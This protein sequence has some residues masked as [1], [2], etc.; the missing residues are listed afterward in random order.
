MPEPGRKRGRERVYNAEKTR[1]AILDA[2]EAV[3]AER[4]FH[5]TA[6][7]AIAAEAGY[8]KSLIFQYFGDK[9]GLYAQVL[10]RADRE[11]N[12][13]LTR[14]FA[15]LLE[16]ETAFQVSQLRTFL[17]TMVQ[18]LF[19]YLLKHPR[20]VRMLTWEMA[21]GWQT[22]AQIASQFSTEDRDQFE[23][24]FHKARSAGLFRSGFV[25]TL[26]LA[27]VG[28]MCLSYLTSLPLYQKLLPEEDVASAESLAQAREY[29]VDFVVAGMLVDSA[30]T[31]SEK[32]S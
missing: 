10:K 31:K 1:E 23:V 25:P 6:V 30:E 3:F 9:L 22:Y 18:T 17:K 26:Q 32:G 5:G 14:V 27:T 8:N 28:Q 4:G 12:E 7:D 21:E 15:T 11:A 20:F 24:L 16:D 13:L 2:A 29:L 19:D